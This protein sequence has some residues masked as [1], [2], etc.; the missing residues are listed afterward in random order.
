[1]RIK[2]EYSSKKTESLIPVKHKQ[3]R[4]NNFITGKLP[5]ILII[6]ILTLT[7]GCSG[8]DRRIDKDRNAFNS[9][10]ENVQKKIR[11]GEVEIGFT[12]EM[13]R[14][15][16]GDPRRIITLT[17]DSSVAEMWVYGERRSNFSLGLG[18]GT[19]QG[20]SA[21]GGGVAVGGDRWNDGENLR[22]TFDSTKVTA[23]ER[24]K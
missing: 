4:I 14:M 16:L 20:R 21:F 22:I 17:T 23:I 13:T 19:M 1:M 2:P 11:A 8:I 15:A 10:P 18:M 7:A 24:R 5:L 12:R 6:S 3:N 9:W